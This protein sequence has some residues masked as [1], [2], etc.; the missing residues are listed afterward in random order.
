M[1]DW[2]CGLD[3]GLFLKKELLGAYDGSP[4]FLASRTLGMRRRKRAR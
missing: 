4:F 2:K 3:P 1:P